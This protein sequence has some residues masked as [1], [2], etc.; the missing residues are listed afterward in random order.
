MFELLLVVLIC[1]Y[2]PFL[3]FY[4]HSRTVYAFLRT[5]GHPK[6]CPFCVVEKGASNKRETLRGS[7]GR[8]FPRRRWRMKW[9]NSSGSLPVSA[10]ERRVREAGTVGGNSASGLP[11]ENLSYLARKPPKRVAFF[12]GGGRASNKRETLRGSRG[13]I[14][15]RRRWRIQ[16]G[17]SSGSLPVNATE[18]IARAARTVG[19]NSA[20]GLPRENLSFSANKKRTFVYRQ[21]CVF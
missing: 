1:I 8:I 16:W 21:K 9:G 19:G 17:I 5:Q 18:R 20:S 10:T 7:R 12:V 15:P 6:G 2:A 13:R 4:L 3:S 11:R 14:S